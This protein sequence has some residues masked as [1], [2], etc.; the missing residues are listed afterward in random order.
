MSCFVGHSVFPRLKG[1]VN[2]SSSD[3]SFNDGN[4]WFTIVPLPLSDQ[5]CGR[6]WR[7][8]KFK[9]VEFLSF[10]YVFLPYKMPKCTIK[11]SDFQIY[12]T[13]T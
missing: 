6:N 1:T 10:L 7:F 8:P 9:S 11:N 3:P 13:D 2:I 5:Y 12:N 4:A